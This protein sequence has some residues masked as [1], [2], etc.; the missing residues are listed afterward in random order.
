MLVNGINVKDAYGA[1]LTDGY[2]YTPPEIS[3]SY[4]KGRKTSFFQMLES[5]VDVGKMVMPITFHGNGLRDVTLK[6]TAFDALIYP[7]AEIQLEDGFMYTAILNKIGDASYV[8]KTA[9]K[10]NYEF[11]VIRHT[12]YV[13]MQGNEVF[14]EFTYPYV[15]CR[16]KTVVEK[17]TAKY[18]LGTVAFEN[19]KA[20]QILEVDGINGRILVDG[21]PGAQYADW[22]E[23]PILV[24]GKNN[25]V[26]NDTVT[27]GYYPIYM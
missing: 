17:D 15:A 22:L 16:L 6:K 5:A 18:Q 12:G 14:C 11:S 20:G 23:F 27:I 13:E 19:I 9:I 10:S 26:C 4:F 3:T 24:P 2:R 1:I 8:G 7:K 25:I 21:A